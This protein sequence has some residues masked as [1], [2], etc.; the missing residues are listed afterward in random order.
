MTATIEKTI[1]KSI[2]FEGKIVSIEKHIVLFD[3]KSTSYREIARHCGGV[4]ILAIDEDDR[5][6]MVK[7]YRKPYE[8]FLL[9]I[10]AGKLEKGETPEDCAE[11][12]LLEETG[13]KADILERLSEIY[14]SPGF[15]DERLFVFKAKDIKNLGTQNLDE[16]EHLE[17]LF[18]PFDEVLEMVQSA[19]IKDAKTMVAILLEAVE[20]RSGGN[21]VKER[22]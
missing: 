16:D 14:P 15:L 19:K 17:I 13:C 5:V 4:G 12:E 6:I 21:Y 7:Q 20:R 22:N 1:E 9:E 8:E 18:I 2:A 10:P 3:D 11:R